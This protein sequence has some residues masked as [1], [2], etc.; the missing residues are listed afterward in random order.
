MRYDGT[1]LG[2]SHVQ[3]LLMCNFS[4]VLNVVLSPGIM[5]Q[6]KTILIA[7]T[8]EMLIHCGLNSCKQTLMLCILSGCFGEV[9]IPHLLMV[10]IY[11]CQISLCCSPLISSLVAEFCFAA[12]IT[13]GTFRFEYEYEIEYEYDFSNPVCVL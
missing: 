11:I 7:H 10:F 12:K 6:S 5:V 8:R 4:K 9:Q 1:F 13:L 3:G 2:L